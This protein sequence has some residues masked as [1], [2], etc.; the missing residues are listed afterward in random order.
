STLIKLSGGGGRRWSLTNE[1]RCLQRPAGS[2]PL[3]RLAEISSRA[4]RKASRAQ[5]LTRRMWGTKMAAR[6]PE[7]IVTAPLDWSHGPPSPAVG[8]PSTL[9]S[10]SEP[11]TAL[12]SN[13]EPLTA[14]TSGSKPLTAL[15]SV[16]KP[17]TALTSGSKPLTALTSGSEPL[18]ALTSES[19]LLTALTS[20]SQPLT[21]LTS[22][23]QPL[24]AL[25]SESEPLTALTSGSKPLTTLTSGSEPTALTSGSE[26]TALTSG[27]EPLTEE[28]QGREVPFGSCVVNRESTRVGRC[29]W[30][31]APKTQEPVD[32]FVV[33]KAGS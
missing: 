5:I 2:F 4:D 17:L 16:S 32:H 19:E 30:V 23:S 28:S 15:T 29:Q 26:P 11:L 10:W 18:T 12:T 13:S 24:T 6:C 22:G 21:A 25:T 31:T 20:G 14:L 1:A 3:R 33:A 8:S 27:S 7:N 9:T